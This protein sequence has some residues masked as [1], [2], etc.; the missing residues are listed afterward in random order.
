MARMKKR[1]IEKVISKSKK[2]D[3]RFRGNDTGEALVIQWS[4]A[5]YWALVLYWA[6]VIGHSMVI[7][8]LGLGYF[9]V[10]HHSSLI[11]HS[12]FGI[13]HLLFLLPIAYCLLAY[14]L[15]AYCLLA[16]CLLAYL[17]ISICSSSISL[18]SPACSISSSGGPNSIA[19]PWFSTMT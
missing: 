11:R 10:I 3:S 7:G 19:L 2:L 16:Y 14:C 5:I 6:L 17:P 12:D 1:I 9:F 18:N 8:Y 15:L 13:R 4:L